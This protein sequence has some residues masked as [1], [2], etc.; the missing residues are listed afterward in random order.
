[1]SFEKKAKSSEKGG[2][3]PFG[4]TCVGHRWDEVATASTH[5]TKSQGATAVLSNSSASASGKAPAVGLNSSLLQTPGQGAPVS[6]GDVV[7]TPGPEVDRE[8]TE[9]T[10]CRAVP[11]LIHHTG[12]GTKGAHAQLSS[13]SRGNAFK[14]QGAQVAVESDTGPSPGAQRGTWQGCCVHPMPRGSLHPLSVPMCWVS[15]R[16]PGW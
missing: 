10:S 12:L 14:G 5:S 7:A 16:G 8:P 11:S 9:E 15:R 6:T 4:K 2:L 13:G 1:M 3:G